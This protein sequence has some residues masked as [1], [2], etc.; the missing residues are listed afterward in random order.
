M[1]RRLILAGLAAA[2]AGPALAQTT[3]TMPSAS[4]TASGAATGNM[5]GAMP[6]G[7]AEMRYMQRTMSAGAAALETSRIAREKAQSAEAKMFATFEVREQEGIADVLKSVKDPAAVT[8][9]VKA[10]SDAEVTGMLDAKGKQMVEKMRGGKAGAEFD[11]EYVMGQLEGH[12]ELLEIQQDYLKSGKNREM[13]NVAKLAS[14][15]IQDHIALLEEMQKDM[16]RKRG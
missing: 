12:R 1:D 14:A 5:A 8:G 10:P 11:K 6:M 2:V 15:H 9:T 16:G 13:V 4:G 3:Q 7:D